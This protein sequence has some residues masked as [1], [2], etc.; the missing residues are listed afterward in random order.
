MNVV[1]SRGAGGAMETRT[2]ERRAAPPELA[3]IAYATL[4]ELEG[5][6]SAAA[7][8]GGGS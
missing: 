3:K 5:T 4:E 8:A 1:S 2:I 6:A 7:A